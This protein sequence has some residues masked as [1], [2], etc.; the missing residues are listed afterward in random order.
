MNFKSVH[1]M[2]LVK[3]LARNWSSR[4]FICYITYHEPLTPASQ[5]TPQRIYTILSQMLIERFLF[6]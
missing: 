1:Q 4:L 6:A 2:K 3:K 5:Y